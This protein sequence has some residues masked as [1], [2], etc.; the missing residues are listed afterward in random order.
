MRPPDSRLSWLIYF[1]PYPILPIVVSLIADNTQVSAGTGDTVRD[2]DRAGVKTQVVGLDVGI[3]GGTE[4]LMSATNPAPI[5]GPD[6]TGSGTISATDAVLGGHAGAGALLSGTP[7][8]NSYVL[9]ALVGGQSTFSVKLSGTFGSGTVWVELSPDSTTGIDGNWINTQA[10][11]SGVAASLLDDSIT[12][13]GIYRGNCAGMT[14]VRFRIT[15]ATTPSVAI[16]SRASRGPG[17]VFLNASIPTGSNVI[18]TAQVK[19]LPITGT[20]AAFGAGA[21]GTVGPVDVSAAS[22]CTFT[23]KNTTAATAFTGG[24]QLW[25]EQ[26]DDNSSWSPLWVQRD[27]TGLLY[28]GIALVGNTANGEVVFAAALTGAAWVRCRVTTGPGANSMTVAIAA[29]GMATAHGVTVAAMPVDSGK[30][31]A[32]SAQ[33]T[34][35][36]QITGTLTQPFLILPNSITSNIALRIVRVRLE[37]TIAT[38]AL[39]QIAVLRNFGSGAGGTSSSG[40]AKTLGRSTQVANSPSVLQYTVAPTAVSSPEIY[41]Q[42]RLWVG[43]S[44]AAGAPYVMEVTFGAGRPASALMILPN[45][46]LGV[47]WNVVPGTAVSCNYEIE[48]TEEPT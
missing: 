23:V 3:G 16:A 7:T 10:R 41:A 2:K 27:D 24:P 31:T 34:F 25:F 38:A 37:L 43:V 46:F 29:S 15:G 17:A 39:L 20:S 14:Y 45:M 33:S 26:S 4:A 30:P 42:R 8:A 28:S 13:A 22:S 12:A 6:L 11:Q 5:Y 9:L 1:A 36:P 35:T 48:W 19:G 32:I 18:G 44:T 47:A 21:T 40:T